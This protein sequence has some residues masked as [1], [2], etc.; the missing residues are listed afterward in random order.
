MMLNPFEFGRELGTEELVDRN[1]EVAA[2]VQTIRQGSKLFL[3]GPRRFGKTSILKV[4][5]DRLN[6]SHAVVLR[7]N[8]ESYPTLDLFVSSLIAAA[9]KGLKGTVER[10]G[11]QVRSFFFHLRPELSFNLSQEAWSVKLGMNSAANAESPV[12]FLV[13]ALN[14][15]E[16]LA[17]AQPKNRPVGLIVDEFQHIIELGGTHA[18]SLIRAAIQQHRRVGYVFAGSKTRMLRDMTM[19]ATR[20][21][22]RL[23][24]VLFLSSVPA[25]DFEDFIGL[26]F[27]E[28]GFPVEDSTAIPMILQLAEHVPYN[29]QMLAHACWNE[30]ST[31]SAKKP[32]GLNARVVADAMALVIRQ[33]DPF[34]TQIWSSLTSI[35]QRTL[36]A[37]IRESGLRLHTQRVAL[38]VGRGASTVQRSLS[39]LTARDILRDEECDGVARLRFEDPFFA[40][41]IRAFP[42]RETGEIP[43]P[44]S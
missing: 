35:Q 32:A 15:L 39:A 29:V 2:V 22:Y 13:E 44:D 24:S 34:Y 21:F 37:V 4:A 16:A 11:D 30:L 23:G 14:G 40:Q 19:D 38:Q 8:A 36:I 1:A 41:W 5:A 12:S 10:V 31:R 7:F 6:Q 20:P 18:E 25:K 3:V 43:A 28:S 33:Y 42:A 27:R 9:A 17:Q 26:K